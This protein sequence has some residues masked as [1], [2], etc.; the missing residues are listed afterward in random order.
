MPNQQN[1]V[2]SDWSN[3]FN[4]R[5][6]REKEVI[7]FLFINNNNNKKRIDEAYLV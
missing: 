2:V 7:L 6:F 5:D 3:C 4:A 1:Q